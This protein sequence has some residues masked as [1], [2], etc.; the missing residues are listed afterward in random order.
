MVPNGGWASCGQ[1]LM[2]GASQSIL[3]TKRRWQNSSCSVVD[4]KLLVSILSALSNW[5]GTR[6]KGSSLKEES[7]IAKISELNG[8]WKPTILVHRGLSCVRHRTP[9]FS[10]LCLA[11]QRRAS[12]KSVREKPRSSARCS[13][14]KGGGR[15]EPPYSLERL[16]EPGFQE[17]AQFGCRLELWNGI[18]F[19][20]GRRE[21]VG[22]GPDRSRPELIVL[23]FE[24]QIVYGKAEMFR[25]LQFAFHE[26]LVNDYL[27]R[28]I[29]QFTSLP[30]LDLLAHRLEVPLHPINANRDAI[31]ERERLRVFCQYRGEIPGERHVGAHEH[32][33]ATGHRQTHALIVGI[34]KSDGKAASFHLGCEVENPKSFHAVSGDRILI[35]NDSDVPEAERLDQGLHDLVVR[36]RAVSFGRR[37]CRH[38]C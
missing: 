21:G 36:D 5:H 30:G 1:L 8:Q 2:P 11:G 34:A 18:Q 6:W 33:I 27:G 32:A 14:I 24:I 15:R 10:A 17:L 13:L 16:R 31:D 3:S 4:L 25:R 37:W 38:Q 7:A 12:G 29:R 28:H 26:R 20:E 35:M 9:P 19:L 22:E 23:R